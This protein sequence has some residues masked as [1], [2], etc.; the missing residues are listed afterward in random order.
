MVSSRRPEASAFQSD[1]KKANSTS[2]TVNR[3]EMCVYLLDRGAFD[4]GIQ[5]MLNKTV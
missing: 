2:N 3:N 1:E 5:C 4:E